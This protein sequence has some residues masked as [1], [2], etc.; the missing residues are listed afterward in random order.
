MKSSI[1]L[2]LALSFASVSSFAASVCL[3]SNATYI[4][5]LDKRF[6]SEGFRIFYTTNSNSAHAV[7]DLTDKNKNGIPDYIENIAI[8]FN[9]S[10]KALNKLGFQDPLLSPRYKGVAKFIDIHIMKIDGNGIAYE[11]PHIH[12]QNPLKSNQC[13]LFI[14]LR[15]NLEGFPGNWSVAH[16]EL[17]HLYEY[18]YTQFKR[19]WFLEAMSA[20]SERLI[21]LGAVKNGTVP[22]PGS[23]SDTEASVFNV[24]YNLM[25]D[26]LAVISDKTKAPLVLS[27]ELLEVKYVNGEKV[28]KDELLWGHAYMKVVLE[29]M[30]AYSLQI[31]Q[32]KKR[33]PYNWK[34][35]EQK[36][37]ALNKYILKAAEEA[38]KNFNP[39]NKEANKFFEV[40]R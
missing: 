39:D 35:E 24:P 4:K 26:R 25:W 34:E 3:T 37:P 17:F 16:H 12:T 31:S 6:T 30:Q 38:M 23:V 32:Q 15:N 27:K 2:T 7:A 21:R 20:W 40:N 36:D 1:A 5:S 8:Q 22:L 29:N 11:V 10:R 19:S 14:T 18:G 28:F 13:A 9:T 33:D